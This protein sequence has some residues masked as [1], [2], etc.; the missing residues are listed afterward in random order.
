M[1]FGD[2][3]ISNNLSVEEDESREPS[4]PI[5]TKDEN[6]ALSSIVYKS[7]PTLQEYAGIP[8]LTDF[9]QMRVFAGRENKDWWMSD[10]YRA[11]EVL[12]Q[13]PW[14]H[15]VDM[16]SIGVVTLELVEGR[17]LFDPIDANG[18]YSLPLALAQYIGY[19]G[20]PPL[21]II[22]Q[23]PLFSTYFDVDGNY[24]GRAPI[25]KASLDDFVTTIRPGIGKDKFLRLIR[26]MLTWD[27]AER[28]EATEILDDKW[29]R[30]SYE[31]LTQPPLWN[32]R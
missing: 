12:L 13:L 26:R 3:D 14:S 6:G 7:R 28:A 2:D 21:K 9:G 32:Q 4:V 30:M 11:P 18:R 25:P 24:I 27:P 22:Q 8:V 5:I 10:L 23:S 31:D 16:W 20:P 19:L 15:P 17:N 1:L 29:F